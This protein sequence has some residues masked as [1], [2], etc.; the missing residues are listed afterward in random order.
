MKFEARLNTTARAWA[1]SLCWTVG[2]M[3]TFRPQ[4]LTELSYITVRLLEI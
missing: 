1:D 4:L 2:K 3:K